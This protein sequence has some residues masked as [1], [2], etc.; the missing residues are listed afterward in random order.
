MCVTAGAEAMAKVCCLWCQRPF[1][2]RRGGSPQR[3]C[4]ARCRTAFWIALRRWGERALAA[5]LLT[6]S[7]VQKNGDP[8]A[9]T[10]LLAANPPGGQIVA[11][12]PPTAPGAPGAESGYGSQQDLETRMAAAVA[13]M[14]RR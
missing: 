12:R 6:V 7:D 2:P 5:G 10:L 1:E 9:C 3:F 8:T 14:R 11:G 4:E 13:R